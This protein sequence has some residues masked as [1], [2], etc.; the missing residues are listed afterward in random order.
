[1]LTD[2]SPVPPHRPHR[3]ACR[4]FAHWALCLRAGHAPYG[5]V[6]GLVGRT[7]PGHAWH[8]GSNLAGCERWATVWFQP[9]SA[10]L[11]ETSYFFPVLFKL[12]QTLKIHI[13]LFK[14]PKIMKPVLLD[15]KF[16]LYLGK[17]LNIIVAFILIKFP[18][19]LEMNSFKLIQCAY[20]SYPILRKR[21]RSLHMSAQDV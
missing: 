6:H 13:S 20:L 17:I 15:L 18:I 12:I 21:K 1:V 8:Y 3:T 4:V 16:E 11:K 7:M 19:I 10:G 2:Q 9:S 5:L 14:A